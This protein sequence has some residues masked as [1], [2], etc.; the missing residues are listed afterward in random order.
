VHEPRLQHPRLSVFAGPRAI[1]IATLRACASDRVSLAAAG[2]AFWATTALFPAISALVAVYGLVFNPISVVRQLTL[3]S[4]LLPPPAYELIHDRVLE[5]VEQ[6]PD[7]LSLNLLVSI[8]LALWSAATGTKAMLSALNVV[9]DVDEKRGILRFHLT[10]LALT[11]LA[12]VG[13]VLAISGV[14]LLPAMLAFVGLS[15]FGEVLIHGASLLLLVGL[16]AGAIALLY[17]VGPSR[18][19]PERPRTAPGAAIATGLW[20]LASGGLSF[21]ISHLASFGATYGSIG[22]VVGIMLWFYISAYAALLGAELNARLETRVANAGH[23]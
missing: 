6:P 3:L 12:V 20:L 22:A 14:V 21:Y 8:L 16:F 23:D 1:A 5:L 2:C 11:C 10:G 15:R 13:A 7:A 19:R 9:Y 4:D 18:D 17:R